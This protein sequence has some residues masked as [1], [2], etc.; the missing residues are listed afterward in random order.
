MDVDEEG[1]PSGSKSKAPKAVTLPKLLKS[2]LQKLLKKK[3]LRYIRFSFSIS[4][5]NAIVV[6]GYSQRSSRRCRARSCTPL[7]SK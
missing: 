6:D 7:T 4:Y 2:K 1:A 3:D 5:A